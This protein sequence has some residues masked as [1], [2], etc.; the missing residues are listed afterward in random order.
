MDPAAPPFG[1][2]DAVVI[3][4]PSRHRGLRLTAV[5]FADGEPRIRAYLHTPAWERIV[6]VGGGESAGEAAARA[7][8]LLE[9]AMTQGVAVSLPHH[10]WVDQQRGAA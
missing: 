4:R 2:R 9:R 6:A 5:A 8:D 7:D 3:E 10:R 1:P